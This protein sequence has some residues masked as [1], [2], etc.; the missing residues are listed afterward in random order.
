[1]MPGMSGVKTLEIIK[2]QHLADKTPVIALTADAIVGARD[3]YIKEGFSDYLSKPVMYDALES[4]IRKYLD[5]KKIFNETQIAK[6]EKDKSQAKKPIILAISDSPDELRDIKA[7]VGDHYKG[8]Y[9]K[10]IASAEKY[11]AKKETIRES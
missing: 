7:L 9:V 4:V 1:M 11:L 8:I 10:D 2:E 3:N 6:L 5:D